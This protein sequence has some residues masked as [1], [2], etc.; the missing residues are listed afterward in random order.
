MYTDPGISSMS[1]QYGD[2]DLGPAAISFFFASHICNPICTAL[3]LTPFDLGAGQKHSANAMDV[4]HIGMRRGKTRPVLTRCLTHAATNKKSA[5]GGLLSMTSPRSAEKTLKASHSLVSMADAVPTEE[6]PDAIIHLGLA[7]LHERGRLASLYAELKAL[8]EGKEEFSVTSNEPP[9]LEAA[10][11]HFQKA[12]LQ[13]S[14]DAQMICAQIFSNFQPRDYL[15]EIGDDILDSERALYYLRLAAR[16][17]RFA[18]LHYADMKF[19]QEQWQEAAKL[20][21][22]AMSLPIPTEETPDSSLPHNVWPNVMSTTALYARVAEC[23][24][25]L[26][27]WSDAAEWWGSAAEEAFCDPLKAKQA[28]QYQEKQSACEAKIE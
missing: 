15:P 9:D 14:V 22:Q 6:T 1:R 4:Q 28:M 18:T 23:Y 19:A 27:K 26:G 5:P 3:G 10:L 11:Y 12:A 16:K 24:E 25:L 7:V 17:D 2:T 21:E 13:G 20:Y 8:S